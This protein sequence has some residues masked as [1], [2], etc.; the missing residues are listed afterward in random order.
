MTYSF[1]TAAPSYADDDERFGFSAMNSAQRSAAVQALDAWAEVAGITFVEVSDA[2]DGGFIRFGTNDQLGIS[3]G[4]AYYPGTSDAN[5]DV[6]IANDQ[7]VNQSPVAGDYG[8]LTL[9]HEIGH[10]IGLKHPGN[11]SADGNGTEGP[12]LP[13]SEDSE[14]YSVMSYNDHPGVS[15]YSQGPGLYDIAAIQ[16]L[17][18]ANT[19]A[20]AGDNTYI[21]N[22]TQN[23]TIRTIW[24]TGGTDT[25]DFSGQT[26][27]A[28]IS[29]LAGS[30]SSVG[31]S[32]NGERASDNVAIAFGVT[33]ENVSAGRGDDVVTGNAANNVLRGGLGDDQLDGGTGTDAALFSGAQAAY[34]WTSSG[35]FLNIS[36]P[37]GS[38]TLSNLEILRFDDGSVNLRAENPVYRFYNSV[39][40]THFY[41]GSAAERDGIIETVPSFVYEGP[42]FATSSSGNQP[43]WRFYNTMTDSHFYTIS[44]AERDWIAANMPTFNFEGEAYRASETQSD[45]MGALYR[46]LNTQTGSHFF[47]ASATEASQVEATIPHFEAEGVAYYVGLL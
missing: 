13:S 6:Y 11:Y 40:D 33:I 22:D 27:G 38:D 16:Y 24:D 9:L 25:I 21:L 36:G 44:T 23:P 19:T 14:Q 34:S 5:G 47:T 17:Y 45:G 41:T 35:D 7:A 39:S 46:F 1:M 18:G 29:L 2:G 37:D 26:T 15:T 12:Y 43:V 4:Y 10:A 20:N 32:G 3:S 28:V 42:N 31:P 8:Y 30:F